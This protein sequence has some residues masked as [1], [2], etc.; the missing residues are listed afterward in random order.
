MDTPPGQV[1]GA[2]MTSS[3]AADLWMSRNEQSDTSEYVSHYRSS[4]SR[5]VLFILVCV[6]LAFLSVGASIGLGAYDIGILN[7]Y[8]ILWSHITG[9]GSTG[10]DDYIVW[11][12]RLP[13]T[14]VGILSGAGLAVG[15]CV[16]QIIL[17]NPLADTYTTGISAGAGFGATLAI[18]AGIVLVDNAYPVV[19]N[20]FVFAL[21]PMLVIMMFSML[22]GGTHIVMIMSGIAMMFFFNAISAIFKM[23]AN[24]NDLSAL[25][26]WEVGSLAGTGWE[27]AAAIFA[28]V[29]AAIFVLL[30]L[31]RRIDLLGSGDDYARSMGVNVSMLRNASLLVVT[32]MVSVVVC[33][34]GLIGFVGLV[35]PHVCRLFVGSEARFLIPA[36]AS[37][38]AML[39]VL[40]DTVGRL[41][42]PPAEI[43]VG[44]ITAFLGAPLFLYLVMRSRRAAWR[45]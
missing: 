29:S 40:A 39:L 11:E 26:A 32:L 44:I 33:F 21:I 6:I 10:L 4:V 35:A 17:R 15:G 14:L 1:P 31:S 12:S 36:S 41:V 23:V 42:I 28:T 2:P 13:R 24:P 34:T 5:K 43:Q 30:V 20:A 18:T 7:S 16:M 8:S 25:Y 22:K 37:F 45:R 9:A 19:F 3:E 27:G 38:G